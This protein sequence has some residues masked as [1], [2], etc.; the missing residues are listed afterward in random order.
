[1]WI[2]SF[3]GEKDFVAKYQKSPGSTWTNSIS[4]GAI[5]ESEKSKA[6]GDLSLV[7]K[8]LA[9]QREKATD[10]EAELVEMTSLRDQAVD[11]QYTNA[12]VTSQ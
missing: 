8:E 11:S 2:F 6:V 5:M 1:M 12:I 7:E 9:S 3:W 4:S 10:L